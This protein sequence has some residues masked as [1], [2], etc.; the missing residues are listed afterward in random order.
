MFINVIGG[1]FVGVLQ[2]DMD[3]G[4]AARTYTLP[5]TGDGRVAQIPALIISIAAGRVVTLSLI[6]I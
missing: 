5:T 1:L 3:V 6:H 4:A 2:H